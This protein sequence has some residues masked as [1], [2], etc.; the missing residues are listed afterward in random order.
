MSKNK[1]MIRDRAVKED[2]CLGRPIEIIGIY[3]NKEEAKKAYKNFIVNGAVN[4]YDVNDFMHNCVLDDEEFDEFS[5]YIKEKY[6]YQIGETFDE[7]SDIECVFEVAN[8]LEVYDSHFDELKE[9]MYVFGKNDGYEHN[10][11]YAYNMNDDLVDVID[12]ELVFSDD[13]NFSS[14]PKAVTPDELIKL[15]EKET[16]TEGEVEEKLAEAY[17]SKAT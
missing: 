8:K 11:E 17:W 1:Y 6:G 13:P 7:N 14:N 15:Y 12:V 4:E 16:I 10:V 9:I 2:C 3:D 5:Q